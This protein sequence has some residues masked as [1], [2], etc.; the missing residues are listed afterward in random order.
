MKIE[1]I[2]EL[3][4]IGIF[5]E[6][7][8]DP[9]EFKQVTVIYGENGRGKSTIAA[10]LSSLLDGN[11]DQIQA[12]ATFGGGSQ[13][14][15]LLASDT[16]GKQKIELK[17]SQWSTLI[18]GML[19]FDQN[20]VEKNVYAGSQVSANHQEALLEFALGAAAVAKKQELDEAGSRQVA[21]T[22]RR[23]GAED[24][25]KGFLGGAA[26]SAFLGL[27]NE[28]DVP[29]KL[30][31]CIK[32]IETSK[33]AKVLLERP[34]LQPLDEYRVDFDNLL[35]ILDSTLE[36]VHKEAEAE[37]LRHLRHLK[38]PTSEKWISD[39]LLHKEGDAC[40]FCAQPV[41]HLSLLAAYKTYFT[42]DYKKHIA[43]V[44]NVSVI[45]E[46]ASSGASASSFNFG[47]KLN[48][49]T[50]REWA[51]HLEI[52]LPE[53]DVDVLEQNAK[54]IGEMLGS[55]VEQKRLSPLSKVEYTEVVAAARALE[56]TIH[57]EIRAYNDAVSVGNGA[58]EAF[59]KDLSTANVLELEK[60]QRRLELLQTRYSSEVLGIVDR[61]NAAD[62]ERR[63]A[64]EDKLRLR[65]E[66]DT[67]MDTL[68]SQYV[69][70]INKWLV[71]FTGGSF[72]V[73]TMKANYQGTGSPRTEYALSVRGGTVGASRKQT[74]ASFQTA[75]SE[76]DKRTLALAFF[77]AR[78][79]QEGERVAD[80]VI[81]FDDAFTS[82]DKPRRAQTVTAIVGVAA[83]AKQLIMLGHDAYFLRD[84]VRSVKRREGLAYAVVGIAR[85]GEYSVLQRDFDISAVCQSDY[86]K[87]YVSLSDYVKS[88]RG[89]SILEVKQSMRTL[90]EGNLHRRFP[91]LIPGDAMLGVA[92][93]EI[94]KAP[95]ASPIECLKPFIPELRE[96]SEFLN[97]FH[98]DTDG[99]S[100]P[101]E[102]TDS[103]VLAYAKRVLEFVHTGGF[104]S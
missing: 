96:L 11:C 14:A 29:E 49:Q 19:V 27:K 46:R 21:A 53:L 98:H 61:R 1:K 24:E 74:G 90:L 66:L 102:V 62:L 31:T 26:L 36:D 99:T 48:R 81:V 93:S 50:M 34:L 88:G 95:E 52:V 45:V 39:G 51:N 73:A 69:D 67:L 15:L 40:P 12:R 13:S 16:K 63:S 68:L 22:R 25:L 103:E 92:L 85:D 9:V 6:Y 89:Q 30:A 104:R 20:F 86:Y 59:R 75:L 44:D 72:S 47:L 55:L 101:S 80:K 87:R 70:G 57:R 28:S 41:D 43:Q 79:E 32:G 3:R 84:F 23:T 2:V 64:E 37:V 76:G 71:K 58:I 35:E 18:P 4:N 97:V 7:T 65:R 91:G 82:L 77:L 94:Q 38:A 42:S 56:E 10:L 5:K 17:E 100:A 54:K 8:K 33:N 78:V 83:K 60:E